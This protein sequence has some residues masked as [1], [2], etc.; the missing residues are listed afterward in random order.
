MALSLPA[1][2]QV[3]LCR[4]QLDRQLWQLRGPECAAL[5]PVVPAATAH[6]SVHTDTADLLAALG[7][8][9]E[10]SVPSAVAS[11][12][13]VEMQSGRVLVGKEATFQLSL[14]NAQVCC[15]RVR[16]VV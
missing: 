13:E 1:S 7:Q 2:H 12:S 5:L 15:V 11:E 16:V 9:C 4:P 14:R 3:L 8:F 6:L 10:A